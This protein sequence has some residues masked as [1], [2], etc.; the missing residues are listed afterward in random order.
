MFGLLYFYKMKK[1]LTVLLAVAILCNGCSFISSL[2]VRNYYSVP[3][4]IEV[5]NAPSI[6]SEN[7]IETAHE[8]LKINKHLYS[9]LTDS[10]LIVKANGLLQVTL[11]P[12]STTRLLRG[13]N[14]APYN[15]QT[16]IIASTDNGQKNYTIVDMKHKGMHIYYF[17]IKP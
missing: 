8:L 11:P 12:H 4:T 2:F 7:Y 9:K 13:H 3:I 6:F 15:E 17:D 5:I 16:C 10:L 1:G 14:K